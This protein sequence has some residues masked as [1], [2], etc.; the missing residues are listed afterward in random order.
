[1]D[2]QFYDGLKVGMIATPRDHFVT[3]SPEEIIADVAA[4]NTEKYDCMPVRNVD[5]VL[6]GIVEMA[7]YF[8]APAPARC[9]LDFVIPLGEEHLRVRTPAS[10]DF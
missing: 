4:R 5:G 10:S 9:V 7:R 3:C 6:L 1:M 8:D 2:T